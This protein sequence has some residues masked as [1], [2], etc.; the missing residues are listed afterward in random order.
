MRQSKHRLETKRHP[1]LLW[2]ENYML[3]FRI[4]SFYTNEGT[5]GFGYVMF[6]ILLSEFPISPPFAIIKTSESGNNLLAKS[7]TLSQATMKGPK[8]HFFP[9]KLKSQMVFHP[10]QSFSHF[11]TSNETVSLFF[12]HINFVE[13]KI[14]MYV[15][16]SVL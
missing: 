3:Q 7:H 1:L 9:Y 4:N 12:R 16:C 13:S 8:I 5:I 2:M 6:W 14:Y 15:V 10:V 11:A